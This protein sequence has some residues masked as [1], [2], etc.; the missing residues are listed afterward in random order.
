MGKKKKGN[1]ESNTP[2]FDQHLI[3]HYLANMH[4]AIEGNEFSSIDEANEFMHNLL[5]ETDEFP[6]PVPETPKEIAKD[7]VYKAFES[8]GKRRTKLA[9]DA[10]KI[11]PD[12]TEAYIFLAEDEAKTPA[13]AISLYRKAFEAAERTLGAEFLADP[14]NVG[15]FWSIWD[16][17]PY[18][19]A[20]EALGEMLWET[21][22]HEEAINLYQ[23]LLRLN[24]SDNQ[25]LRYRLIPWL[26]IVNKD[27][28]AEKLINEYSN[29]DTSTMEYLKMLVAFRRYGNSARSRRAL[30]K[31]YSRNKWA[32]LYLLGVREVLE[33][34]DSYI[35]YS[36]EE[37]VIT[38]IE[39][40][41]AWDKTPDITE[42]FAMIILE[43]A[44]IAAAEPEKD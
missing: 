2:P 13:E 35:P 16:T 43:M 36:E 25:G 38:T 14:D 18:M 3:N 41:E 26:T 17:R 9:H 29:E 11:D 5:E 32:P 40:M 8:K 30:Q 33:Y 20:G 28:E 6:Q 19:R 15:H 44:L 37:G 21:N 10:L 7:L 42:W 22:A 23:K 34:P 39:I 4:K 27:T 12:C 24:P 31:A 1:A